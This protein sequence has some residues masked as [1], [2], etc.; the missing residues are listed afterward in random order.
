MKNGALLFF[1]IF[2]IALSH[3]SCTVNEVDNRTHYVTLGTVLFVDL[4]GGF[5]GIIDDND[6]RLDPVNL[7][8]GYQ[9]DGLRVHLE[10]VILDEQESVHQWGTLIEIIDVEPIN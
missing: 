10:F 5:Y 3:S 1:A 4:E 6:V 2:V 7:P 8:E 9:V